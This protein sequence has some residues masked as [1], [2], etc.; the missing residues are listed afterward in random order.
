ME[1]ITIHLIG[2]PLALIAAV[3]IL[4]ARKISVD[5][6]EGYVVFAC[7]WFW[8]VMLIMFL[9]VGTMVGTGWLIS[10]LSG[11]EEPIGFE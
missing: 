1:P 10:R 5:P 11:S 4:R 7:A 6:Y 3:F 8:P 2:V 9:F